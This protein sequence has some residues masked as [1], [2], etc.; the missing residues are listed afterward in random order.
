[1][2]LEGVGIDDRGHGISSV[3][4]AVDEF[5]PEC[6][7]EREAQKDEGQR[8]GDVD[9]RKIRE[10]MCAGIDGAGNER[11]AEDDG[12]HT[13][14]CSLDLRIEEC[15][16]RSNRSNRSS[17]SHETVNRITGQCYREITRG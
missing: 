1:V 6:D 11:D 7:G 14:R 12:A 4:E 17:G 16:S 13:T 3:V 8:G 9:L 5:E 2:R 15:F 10:K